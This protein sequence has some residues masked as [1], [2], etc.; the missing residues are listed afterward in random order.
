MP[1]E[2]KIKNRPAVRFRAGPR[3]SAIVGRKRTA[4]LVL[5]NLAVLAGCLLL[6]EV[7]FR[8]FWSP[9][10][11]VNANRWKIGSGQTEAGKKWWPDTTY[12]V[13]SAEFRVTFRTNALGYRA[14]PEPVR[15]SHPYRVAFVGDSFTEAMQVAYESTFCAR[16]E[17]LLNE[18]DPAQPVVCENDG[19]SATDLLDYWHRI[20][21][22]VLAGDP[23]DAIVLCIYPGNDFLCDFP[24]DA[25][26]SQ[27][28]ALRDYFQKPQ[29]T[30]HLVAWIN[31]HSKFGCYVQ[32]ALL[33]IGA[34]PSLQPTQGPKNWWANPEVAA[35]AAG[36]PAVRRSRS[37]IEAI[38]AECRRHGTKLCIL[39]VG[40][41][42]T[43]Q[44]KNGESPLERILASWHLEIPV[45]D[46]AIKA[47]ARPDHKSLTFPGDGHLNDAGHALIAQEAAPTLQAFL[48]SSGLGGRP[49]TSPVR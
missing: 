24:D 29:W 40:P 28:R 7:G 37:L 49:L 32:R 48:E 17:R 14:R 8:L 12:S 26:D 45:I 10:Y 25:F 9:K 13:E 18:H 36:A 21:H 22:D 4:Y 41:V 6:A 42:D 46:V 38:D 11:W 39:V 5:V 16:L 20:V 34:R 1:V 43:Y 27:G 15:A 30:Q 33:S 35:R 19:V 31:L 47:V 23:P 3:R 2:S 44:E